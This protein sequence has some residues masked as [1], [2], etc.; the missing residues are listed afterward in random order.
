MRDE[1]PNPDAETVSAGVFRSLAAGRLIL[2]SILGIAMLFCLHFFSGLFLPVFLAIFLY[3][4]FRPFLD[5]LNRLK[6]PDAVGAAVIVLLMVTTIAGGLYLLAGPAREWINKSPYML[7]MAE[8]KFASFVHTLKGAK[9]ATQQLEE[10]TQLDEDGRDKE[11]VVVQS[12]GL[13]DRV[14]SKMQ[15]AAAD[16]AITFV[17]LYFMLAWIKKTLYRLHAIWEDQELRRE[18]L[19]MINQIQKEVSVY[20]LTIT[21]INGGLAVVTMGA[22]FLLDVPNPALWGVL[23]GL[24]NYIQYLGPAI[25]FVMLGSVAIMT[26]ESWVAMLAPPL[27]YYAMTVIEGNFITPTVLGKRLTLNPLMIFLSLFFWGWLWGIIG[28][29]LAIPILATIKVISKNIDSLRALREALR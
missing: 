27:I 2:L 12:P 25:T 13:A 4:V 20:L 22:M 1:T 26:F 5:L 11:K 18:R 10:M 16:G 3:I 14:F 29:I 23:A 17:L 19:W 9:K 15:S 6:I 24:L 28:M 21:L 7:R 8:S